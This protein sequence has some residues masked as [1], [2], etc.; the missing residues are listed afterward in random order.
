M[1]ENKNDISVAVATYNGSKFL[2]EQ[3]LSII[4]QTFVPNEIIIVDDCSK[5]NTVQIIE[6]IKKDYP[7]IKLFTNEINK[8]PVETF[9]IAISKCSGN[10]IALCDQDDIWELNKLELSIGELKKIEEENVPSAV[11]TDLQLIDEKGN[12]IGETFWESQKL[13]PVKMDFYRTL[14][15]NSLT[16]CTVVFNKSMKDELVNIPKEVEMHD[17]WI[18][19]IALGLG[20]SKPLSFSTVKYRSHENS[21]TVKDS[22]SNLKRIKKFISILF[23]SDRNYMQSNFK[24]ADLFLDIYGDKLSKEKR[25]QLV[26]FIKL[27]NKNSISRNIY[28]GYFKYLYIYS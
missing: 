9:E 22:I 27:G 14:F 15:L 12:I 25:K 1:K 19:L 17:Y 11:F 16:G 10:Y 24:Q 3:L 6:N 18:A 8:G 21:V 4:N 2:Y 23:S 13:N 5:D 28:I 7:F 26:N 20:R